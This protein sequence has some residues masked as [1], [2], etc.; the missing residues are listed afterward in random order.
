M[1]QRINISELRET[2]WYDEVTGKIYWLI[3]RGKA[4]IGSEAGCLDGQGYRIIAINR[5]I[6]QAH[7]IA[8]ALAYGEWAL[9]DI[10]H[11]NLCKSDNRLCNLRIATSSQNHANMS[12]SIANSSG[13][14]G[15]CWNKKSQKWQSG[16]KVQGRSIHLGLFS[17][18]NS[19]AEAYKAAALSYFKEFARTA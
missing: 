12:V 7:Q 5:R 13:K 19:A 2:L 11:K 1:N 3:S 15:V 14:K 17:D 16:I 6:Y 8:W 18:I 9:A 4:R 10:D